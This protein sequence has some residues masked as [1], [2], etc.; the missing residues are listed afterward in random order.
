MEDRRPFY[1]YVDEFQNFA[2][3]S[4][5]VILSEA[6]KFGL[7]L[8]VANQY[9][10]QMDQTV[11]DAVFGNVGSI[12]TGRV[13]ADDAPYLV[14][15]F[16]PQFASGDL[17]QLAN[18]DFITSMTIAG[19]KAPAFSFRSLAMPSTQ[20]DNT[21]TIIQISHERYS[22]NRS[23]VEDMIQAANNKSSSAHRQDSPS[24][25]NKRLT[26]ITTIGQKDSQ[27]KSRLPLIGLKLPA[28]QIETPENSPKKKRKRTRSRRK[29]KSTM[30][31]GTSMETMI[32]RPSIDNNKKAEP[33]DFTIRLR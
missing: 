25:D 26:D 1:L 10:S 9:I 5:A 14:K 16:E 4:F 22:L 29:K 6:R 20:K 17:V 13:S 7:C 12:I 30:E 18:R 8:T 33:N 15:Y 3:D 23:S 27:L 24:H 19:E 2:T 31:V 11:R 28:V 21:D 32:V